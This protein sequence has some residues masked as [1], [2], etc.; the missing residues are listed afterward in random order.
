MMFN[1]SN[2]RLLNRSQRDAL[3]SRYFSSNEKLFDKILIA[4]RGEIACRVMRTAKRLGIKTV[5]VFSEPDR[6]SVHVRMA[7]EAYCIGPAAS[8]ESYLSIPKIMDVIKKSGAQ[9]V[10][11][12]YG[13]LS[14]NH[15]FSETLEKAGIAFMG[16]RG[17]SMVAMGD[18]I[19][20]KKLAAKAGVN[21]IP[22]EKRSLD[23]EKEVL[24]VSNK[25][26]Y[27]V[28]I[29]ASAGGGG[30]GMRI[31]WNDEE[32]KLGYR[33]SKQEAKKSF[34]DD[35]MFVEKYIE[36]PRHIE[37]Q[38][39]GD[40]FGNICAL[41]ERECS[42]Q[43][44]NQK[45]LEEAPSVLLDAKTR[46]AMQDQARMLAKAVEY[47]SA[48]TVEFLCDKNKNFY[49]LEMNTR[50]QV[51]H[52]I[53]ELITG[54]DLV[55]QMI[56]V[57]AGYKL[58]DSFLSG[59]L[60]FKGHAHEA[61][62]YAEDPLRGFLPSIGRLV[63]YQEPTHI[64]NCR[65]DSG[66]TQGSEISM[67]YDPMI[68]KLCGYGE[69]RAEALEV[70]S[71]A[72]DSYVIGG[73]N[74]N[75]AF[76][77]DVTRSKRFQEGAITTKYIPEEYPNGFQGV[78]L[79]ETEKLNLAAIANS[80]YGLFFEYISSV[81]NQFKRPHLEKEYFIEFPKLKESFRV[82]LDESGD[83]ISVSKVDADGNKIGEK[84]SLFT[85]VSWDP[86]SIICEAEIEG[87][88]HVVQVLDKDI[89]GFKLQYCGAVLDA[90]IYNKQEY[91]LKKH[92]IQKAKPDF[93]KYLLSPMPGQLISVAVKV[94]DEIFGGQEVCVVEAMKMQNVLR[95]EKNGKVKSISKKPGQT[96]DVDEI[97]VEFE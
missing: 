7:D 37:I 8:S 24:E 63:Q 40:S 69:T 90:K 96:V 21:T 30:K 11:P 76:L 50:L 38:L 43:R 46:R 74:H 51:E 71:K 81:N 97:L 53:T 68:S 41:P 4:N 61:R 82:G 75:Q 95:A 27:P 73:L 80:V 60:P 66:I 5:A 78:S 48:G 3:R 32:A 87:A 64:P 70:L 58:P 20:S 85:D 29:K 89:T 28:M 45:V 33:L 52:P 10:H 13:F 19:E 84:L 12:G 49:F 15:V 16:P 54:V 18:K 44:R 1:S 91:K 94:G 31:A 55:E 35:R 42:I 2:L 72:L 65:V 83:K 93:S 22:G 59:Y 92:M 26:G 34:G 9:A 56:R 39:I 67:F 57:A 6:N 14:E 79:T 88:S 77:R 23:S 47:R 17:H 86:F 62:V 36:E 25:I